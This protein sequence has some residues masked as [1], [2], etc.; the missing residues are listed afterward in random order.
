MAVS[1]MSKADSKGHR[2]FVPSFVERFGHDVMETDCRNR[3]AV[4]LLQGKPDAHY[5]YSKILPMEYI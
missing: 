5:R 2:E 3:E 4:S 1:V